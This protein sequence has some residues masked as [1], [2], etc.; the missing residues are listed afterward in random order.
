MGLLTVC[1]TESNL[2]STA[3]QW[4]SRC[5]DEAAQTHRRV[6]FVH[7]NGVED[8]GNSARQMGLYADTESVTVM[9]E[10]L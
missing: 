5:P 10:S 7:R 1:V 2:L 9:S 8:L 6:M 3:A 4:C